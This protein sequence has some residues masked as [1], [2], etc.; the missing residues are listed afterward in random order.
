MRGISGL[1]NGERLEL[2]CIGA[3]SDDIEI[4]CAGTILHLLHGHPESRVTWIVGTAE[5]ERRSEAERSAATLL[6]EAGE[7]EIRIGTFRDGHFPWEGSAIKDFLEDVARD[8]R[9]DIVFTH[10]RGDRHQDHRTL[11]DLTWTVFRDH[12]I[13]E[14]EIIK[15]DGD[16]GV[17]NLYVPL[18]GDIARAKVEHLLRHF[19]SQLRRD[20]FSAETFEALMRVRAVESRAPSGFAEAFHAR[21][22]VL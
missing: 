7:M 16:L 6:A 2:L 10:H 12:L 20:W 1:R 3:H 5:D 18:P 11:S 15:F 19:P 14:Y 13:L 22:V 17:P 9:P 4:G 8:V 21:K